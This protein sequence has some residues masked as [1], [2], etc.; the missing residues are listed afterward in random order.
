VRT[1]IVA[2]IDSTSLADA[3]A[4]KKSRRHRK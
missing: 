4:P 1:A 2:V 3:V